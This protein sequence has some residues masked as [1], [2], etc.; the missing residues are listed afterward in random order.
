M[1]FSTELEFMVGLPLF[2]A[3]FPQYQLPAVNCGSEVH[4]LLSDHPEVSSSLMLRHNACVIHQTS[5][6]HIGILSSHIITK[7]MA[8]VQ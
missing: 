8:T 4:D 3:H 1:L 7:R 6:H 2:M 5:S